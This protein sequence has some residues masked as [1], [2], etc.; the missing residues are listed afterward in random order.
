MPLSRKKRFSILRFFLVILGFLLHPP[1]EDYQGFI[2]FLEGVLLRTRS[3]LIVC[4]LLPQCTR[5]H[6]VKTSFAFAWK[7]LP[8]ESGRRHKREFRPA[9]LYA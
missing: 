2:M 3:C 5:G 6:F 1:A 9:F 4:F 8:L 7:T